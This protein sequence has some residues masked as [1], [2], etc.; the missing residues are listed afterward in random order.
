MPFVI[1]GKRRNPLT[2]RGF[3]RQDRRQVADAHNRH[4][5]EDRGSPH[6]ELRE[7]RC[8]SGV[9][10]RLFGRD[11]TGSWQA[12]E[13]AIV[14]GSTVILYALGPPVVRGAKPCAHG[15]RPRPPGLLSS[16]PR[17]AK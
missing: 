15:P 10:S 2:I 11:C 14:F 9:T 12:P 7:F 4:L 13:A 1:P 3:C 16:L 8:R 17:A 5:C 6:T